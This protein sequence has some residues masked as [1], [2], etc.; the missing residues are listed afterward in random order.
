MLTL[1]LIWLI[2]STRAPWGI[3]LS[4]PLIYLAYGAILLAILSTEPGKGWLGYLLKS[5]V[6]R[7]VAW[8]GIYSYSI[9]LWHLDV[10]LPVE[11]LVVCVK[12]NADYRVC[13][14]H[15]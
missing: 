7:I 4:F 9:Y 14:G 12:Q 11:V 15:A 1:F 6:G 13:V 10:T 3:A 2:R 5:G 8:A